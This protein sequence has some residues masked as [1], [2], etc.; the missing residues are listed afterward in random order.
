MPAAN[1]FANHPR[2]TFGHP[3]ENEESPFDAALVEQIQN[4]VGVR[5]DA[6]RVFAPALPVHPI[7]ESFHLKI[8]LHV[9]GQQAGRARG[10]GIHLPYYA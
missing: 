6:A 7:G 3:A 8:I 4:R 1:N 5:L 9:D 10:I 2:K